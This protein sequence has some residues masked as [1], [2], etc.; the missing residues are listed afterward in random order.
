MP[1]IRGCWRPTTADRGQWHTAGGSY[2]L[3]L[4]HSAGNY[5]LEADV[6]LAET[7]FGR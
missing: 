7:W 5:V 2:R 1:W 4:G 3:V 6:S